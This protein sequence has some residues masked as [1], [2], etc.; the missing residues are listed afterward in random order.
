MDKLALAATIVMCVAS[1]IVPAKADIVPVSSTIQAAVDAAEPGDIIIVPPGTYRESV[2]VLKDNITI[3]GPEKA[4][5]DASGFVN[6][7]HVGA[8]IFAP[9]KNPVCP[10]TAVH[11]FTVAGLTV[12]NAEF[13]G[14]F[15][16]GVDGYVIARG[17]YIN[18]GNYA[19]YPSCSNNGHIV[20]NYAKGGSDTC[21]YIGNDVS[22]S[23]S[24]NK[25]SGCTVGIQIVNS[26]NFLVSGN[27][28]TGNTAGI[29]AIVDPLNPRIETSD[30]L[31]EKN[32]VTNNNL[33][34]T[35]TDGDIG[36]IPSGTGILNVATDRLTI[37]ENTVT[38]NNTL[39]VAITA[40]PLA[41]EDSR[42]NPNPDGNRVLLNTVV[43]NGTQPAP[44]LPGADLFYD[45]NGQGNC[46]SGNR[47]GTAVP[48][49]IETSF[50]CATTTSSR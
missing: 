26:S 43:N 38:G 34:N 48:P 22:V 8:D 12:R 1:E 50:P 11:N 4:I 42:I 27:T 19:T 24:G 39:G 35:S 33:Q 36:S 17:K 13:N 40:N 6:G 21:L 31:I 9:S 3:V 28:V 37:R 2:R 10:A 47:F 15:L 46:F 32:T 18:N 30:G 16:S 14:I 23:V 7:I 5:I 49:S 25:A 41:V 44:T 45:G 20:F 29:L